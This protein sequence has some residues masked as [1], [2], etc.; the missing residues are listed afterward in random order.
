MRGTSPSFFRAWYLPQDKRSGL[1]CLRPE[2]AA[3]PLVRQQA[4]YLTYH[5]HTPGQPGMRHR[6]LC[7]P[8]YIF[9]LTGA[10]AT[11]KRGATVNRLR[12]PR[13]RTKA[14]GAG[15]GVI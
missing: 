12:G 14:Q 5:P 7:A 4:I 1:L 15:T 6:T 9:G 2:E 13:A 11:T 10:L 3:A 8:G